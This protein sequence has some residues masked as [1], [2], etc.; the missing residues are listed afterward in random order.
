MDVGGTK[1]KGCRQMNKEGKERIEE[2]RAKMISNDLECIELS[3]YNLNALLKLYQK[4][5]LENF[6]NTM[7]EPFEVFFREVTEALERIKYE[8]SFLQM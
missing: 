4:N 3:A 5:G 8:L 6:K 1:E 2:L 7:D